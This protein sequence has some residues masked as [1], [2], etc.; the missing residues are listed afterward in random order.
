MK[1]VFRFLDHAVQ[2][3]DW[4]KLL[5]EADVWKMRVIKA[6]TVGR[7]GEAGVQT[8]EMLAKRWREKDRHV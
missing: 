5:H 6:E 7:W 2:C 1:N 3:I 8:H 4:H